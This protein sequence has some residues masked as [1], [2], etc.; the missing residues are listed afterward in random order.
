MVWNNFFTSGSLNIY[1][2]FQKRD[3]QKD[4]SYILVGYKAYLELFNILLWYY[5]IYATYDF[6]IQFLYDIIRKV[7]IFLKEIKL[8]I[9]IFIK[10]WGY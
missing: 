2:V 6:V 5:A 4:R 3:S 9:N 1:F 8:I 7:K 10:K